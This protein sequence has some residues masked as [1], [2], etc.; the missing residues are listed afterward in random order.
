MVH[1]LVRLDSADSAA[2]AEPPLPRPWRAD[3]VP[4]YVVR[5]ESARNQCVTG[6]V[7]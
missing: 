4:G 7:A 2:K 3:K 6:G 1:V 5:L